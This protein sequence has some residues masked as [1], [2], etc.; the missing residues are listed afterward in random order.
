MMTSFVDDEEF[1]S[2]L[3]FIA[4][5]KRS[6]KSK[7]NKPDLARARARNRRKEQMM[8]NSADLISSVAWSIRHTQG[9]ASAEL[10]LAESLPADI[11]TDVENE[12]DTSL[13]ML[14][15]P[16][17]VFQKILFQRHWSHSI[18]ANLVT[19]SRAFPHPKGC[20]C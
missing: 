4:L 18:S 3:L 14:L 7:P 8:M 19:R 6:Y 2:F 9:M 11:E 15:L 5:E 13:S 20:P 1:C 12:T 16:W 10:Q 17:K